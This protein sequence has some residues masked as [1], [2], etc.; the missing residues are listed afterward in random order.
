L[1]ILIITIDWVKPDKTEGGEIACNTQ[2]PVGDHS[3]QTQNSK[4]GVT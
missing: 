4:R 1:I 3:F 2:L